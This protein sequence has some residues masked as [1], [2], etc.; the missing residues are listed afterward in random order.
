[1]FELYNLFITPS[2]AFGTT[3]YFDSFMIILR[4]SNLKHSPQSSNPGKQFESSLWFY[5]S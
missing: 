3:W 2:T 4:V 5:S 1:M